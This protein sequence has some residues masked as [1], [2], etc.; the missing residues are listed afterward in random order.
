V[1]AS[2]GTGKT[3]ALA[4]LVLRLVAE[5]GWPLRELLV[6]TYTDA[7]AAELRDRVGRRLQLALS[8]LERLDQPAA[9]DPGGE[10]D[11]ADGRP[12]ARQD[13]HT[14]PHRSPRIVSPPRAQRH[15]LGLDVLR[16]G[17]HPD[18]GFG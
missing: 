14:R 17:I 3:F 1:E 6:V 13:R 10:S 15:D 8:L 4:H 5:Q 18:L 7:A 9:V 11:P 12:Q 16:L 2:A